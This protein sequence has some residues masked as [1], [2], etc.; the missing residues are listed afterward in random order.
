MDSKK[1][2]NFIAKRRKELGL[3][4]LDLANKLN[5]TDRAISK[6]ENGRG[7]PD[8]S[9]IKPLCNELKIT[10]N[11]L[12]SGEKLQ[13]SEIKTKS[14]ENIINTLD[15]SKKKQKNYIKII[16]AATLIIAI[17][18]ITLFSMFLID[19]NRMRNNEQVV[20]STWGFKYTAPID[21][22]SEKIEIAIENYLT[23]LNDLE[24]KHHKDEKYFVASNIYLI[25]ETLTKAEYR[26]YAWVYGQSY[27]PNENGEI[28][29]GS[30]YSCPYMI[31]VGRIND[32]YY[33]SSYETPRDGSYYPQ[34]MKRL[35]PIYV[36]YQMDEV[37]SD[38]TPERLKLEID[39]RVKE[40]FN[41]EK[42]D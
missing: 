10:V 6:W 42:L 41:L 30:G 15:Y 9:L 28:V 25:E 36:R 18:I 5:I 21:L 16:I 12:L 4:Q 29:S 27:Y 17:P 31:I 14:E 2:G 32:D 19:F 33:V 11:D 37:Y 20:F 40:Y 24:Y 8:I 3:T 39:E 1:I 23:E 34:D 7:M 38:G 13:E 35:F 22:S 26:V